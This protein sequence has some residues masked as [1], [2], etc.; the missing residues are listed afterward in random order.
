MPISRKPKHAPSD[1]DVDALINR[2]GT[3]AVA[4]PSDSELPSARATVAVNLRIP[5]PIIERVDRVL[6]TLPLKKPRHAWLLEAVLEKLE[7]EN[8]G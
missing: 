1:V 7:R 2:G 8:S 5:S 6:E 3:V 4:A